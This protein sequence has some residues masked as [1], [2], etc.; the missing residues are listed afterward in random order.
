SSGNLLIAHNEAGEI[1]PMVIDIGRAWVW[2]GPGS[3][4]RERHR[5]QDL[6]RIAYKLSWDDR[7][8][9]M[10]A[11]ERHFGRNFSPLWRL[12]FHYY[13][14]KQRF[15]KALKGKRKKRSKQ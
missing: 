1:V 11:Y 12:P 8:A 15:K 6:M 7:S 3:R 10:A 13:D 9:F 14:N 5:L 2:R 4:L